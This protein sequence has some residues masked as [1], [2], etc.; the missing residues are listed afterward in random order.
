MKKQICLLLA[1]AFCLWLN[2]NAQGAIPVDE[3]H[4][5][6]AVF[7]S[8]VSLN[9]DTNKDGSL[10][11]DEI[12]QA[13]RFDCANSNISS[14]KGVEYLTNLSSLFCGGNKL[15]ELDVSKNTWL[16]LLQC[17]NN[18]L[19]SLNL[20]NNEKLTYINVDYNQLTAI[21]LSKNM[22]LTDVYSSYN[23]FTKI[24]LSNHTSLTHF[25]CLGNALQSINVKGCVA[26]QVFGCSN[27]NLLCL[28]LS[29]NV[30]LKDFSPNGNTT[31]VKLDESK[32]FD[33]S[34]VEGIDVSKMS[35]IIGGT[36]NG[37]KLIFDALSVKYDY[38]CGNG[39]ILHS[40]IINFPESVAIN[41]KNF[42]DN[43]FSSY[44]R[45]EIDKNSD[46]VLS[47]DEVSAIKRIICSGRYIQ[48]LKGIE[49]FFN[50][51]ELMCQNN[52]ITNLDI[53]Q[54]E[55]LKLLVF[56]DNKLS[57]LDVSH[58]LLISYI[59]VS[60]N[61]LTTLD[62]SKNSNLRILTC[63]ANLL[64]ELNLNYNTN[65]SNLECRGNNLSSLDLSKNTQLVSLEA[66]D[67]FRVVANSP[68][69]DLTTFAG[70]DVTKVT[71]LIDG[72]INGNSLTLNADA[73]SYDYDCGNGH[74]VKFTLIKNTSI[75]IDETNFPDDNFRNRVKENFDIDRNGLLDSNERIAVKKI[76]LNGQDVGSLK[77]IENFLAL[78]D[79]YIMENK[80]KTLNLSNNE[81]LTNLSC[82]DN[83]LETLDLSKNTYLFFLD[84][85]LNHLT[86][87]DLSKANAKVSFYADN[88]LAAMNLNESNQMD[89]S[90]LQGFDVSKASNWIG[91]SVSG[92]ILTATSDK[93]TYDYDCGKGVTA[94][95]TLAK[96]REVAINEINFPDDNFREYIKNRFDLNKDDILKGNEANVQV[97]NIYGK[98]I[99]SIKGIEFFPDLRVL[100]C[101]NNFIKDI[102]VTKNL[103]LADFEFDYNEV[104]TIDVSK[105][106]KLE[107]FW[108]PGNKLTH[109]DVSNNVALINL[110]C[111]NN[112]L[113]RLDLTK[114]VNLRTLTCSTNMLTSLDLSQNVNLDRLEAND[115]ILYISKSTSE[116][117]DLT[118]LPGF[119]VTKASDWTGATVNGTTLA[120][121]SN[122]V[123]YLYDCGNNQSLYFKIINEVPLQI[124]ETNFPDPNFRKAIK[125]NFDIDK[126]GSLSGQEIR[127][128]IILD[129]SN[130]GVKNLKGLGLLL[131]L[132]SL[133]ASN[134]PLVSADISSLPIWDYSFQGCERSV[135]TDASR[136]FDLT[137]LAVDG[138]DLQKVASW[139][140]GEVNGNILTF[141]EGIE[142][143]IATYSYDCGNGNYAEFRLSATISAG[144]DSSMA[145]NVKVVARGHNILV[146][147]TD[148]PASVYEMSGME[149]Y[150]GADRSISIDASG[151]YIVKV[152]GKTFKVVIR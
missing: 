30:N 108:C 57:S 94:K 75:A 11:T 49:F 42:P 83:Q 148:T 63:N 2:V 60:G 37:T 107:E 52:A 142:P 28:D 77:G 72:S 6:D 76:E 31:I 62:V 105:N 1:M 115:N 92:N 151:I 103:E 10:S 147:G 56:S 146:S 143:M 106:V 51:E 12:N 64:K 22:A 70:F 38:D 114:N 69:I 14:L 36:L 47:L 109:L 46:G 130:Q 127:I 48:S 74:T 144:L 21:D 73:S 124:N 50:L 131:N 35:N 44:L 41:E 98:Y 134:N 85:N 66:D 4:F 65:L 97:L 33:L 88:N 141:N 132:R 152:D 79:L 32:T 96:E 29:T 24:D 23:K 140:G 118:K 18:S 125:D 82:R 15:A 16:E 119:D 5:P 113:D 120:M 121:T 133:N 126:D 93:V 129:I 87:L 19:T 55:K 100:N 68:T 136:T 104:S 13:Q 43:Q 84:C 34:S 26:L 25:N 138:F 89:L 71:N 99:S 59:D 27:N 78:T 112:M 116:G 7:R 122:T 102:D 101:Y 135:V 17:N 117:F 111:D 128:A 139:D 20:S 90:T 110:Y 40:E 58:Q 67:N 80:V 149:V 61:K 3:A 81:Y 95:F 45:S 86:S 39:H 9:F 150:S 123:E 8:K 91:G 54:N 145:D 53:S 137:T